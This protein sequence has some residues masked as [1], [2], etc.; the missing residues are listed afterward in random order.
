MTTYAVTRLDNNH[1]WNSFHIYSKTS[2]VLETMQAYVQEIK[3]KYPDCDVRLTTLERAKAA[4]ARYG[5]WYEKY[6]ALR[7][8]LKKHELRLKDF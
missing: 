7:W 1:D 8:E 5:V 2:S 6:E 4:K 3:A